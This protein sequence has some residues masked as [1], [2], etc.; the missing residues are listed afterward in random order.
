M[1]WDLKVHLPAVRMCRIECVYIALCCLANVVFFNCPVTHPHWS[2]ICEC[3][4]TISVPR[5]NNNLKPETYFF[6]GSSLKNKTKTAGSSGRGIYTVCWKK[7]SF[8]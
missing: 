3:I 4:H 2:H 1:S 8:K 7:S 6:V 5:D